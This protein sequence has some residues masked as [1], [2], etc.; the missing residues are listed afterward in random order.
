MAEIRS[1]V[2][3]SRRSGDRTE[4]MPFA[5]EQA[6]YLTLAFIAVLAGLVFLG[7]CARETRVALVLTALGLGFGVP[8]ICVALFPFN[9]F[10]GVGGPKGKS[11]GYPKIADLTLAQRRVLVAFYEPRSRRTAALSVVCM[12]LLWLLCWRLS[13]LFLQRPLAP[14]RLRN[15]EVVVSGL[16]PSLIT[17]CWAALFG[18]TLQIR[19]GWKA[20]V[21]EGPVWPASIE[22]PGPLVDAVRSF[23][24]GSLPAFLVQTDDSGDAEGAG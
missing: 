3:P 24:T 16:V 19:R 1:S 15:N 22:F 9:V 7:V 2:E 11:G 8:G 20:I 5:V 12:A 18:L 14:T 13:F 6:N 17:A 23:F 4:K 10:Y 21:A